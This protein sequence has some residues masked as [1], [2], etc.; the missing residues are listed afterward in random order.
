[1]QAVEC[2]I[3]I[4][5]GFHY[6]WIFP[7]CEFPRDMRLVLD[8][9]EAR[10]AWHKELRAKLKNRDEHLDSPQLCE[11]AAQRYYGERPQR[12]G[13]PEWRALMYPAWRDVKHRVQPVSVAVRLDDFLVRD[14]ATW[15]REHHGIIWYQ[16]AAFGEWLAELSGLPL[17]G[18]GD[19]AKL[20]LL[21]NPARGIRGE[22]GSRS[23]ICSMPAHGTGTNGLQYRFCEQLFGNNPADPA[24][25]EQTL[26]RT[27]RAGQRRDVRAWYY[28][29]TRELRRRVKSALRAALYVEGTTGADQKLRVGFPFN[30]LEGYE[31][32]E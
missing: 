31:D 9:L 20:A 1:M 14:A 16:H 29:H 32:E 25:W 17:F 7:R 13:L 19:E 24:A 10:K 3:Q 8:W 12:K 6:K 26:G 23:V 18:A 30:E 21:G 15:A 28:M 11:H 27:H 4:A 2:A 5:H 22:D